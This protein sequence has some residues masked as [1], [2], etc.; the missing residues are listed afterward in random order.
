MNLKKYYKVWLISA[1]LSLSRA[2][3]TKTASLA[4]TLGKFI[5]FFFFIFFLFILGGNLGHISGYE[6]HQL[7][8]FYLVFNL[9]DIVG[10]VFFR[11]IYMFRDQVISGE[12]DFRLVKPLSPLFQALTRE[13]DLLDVPLLVIVLIA[14][15]RQITT[16]GTVNIPNLIIASVSSLV[17]ITAIH[18][19][20]A[21]FGLLTTQVDHTMWVYRDISSMVRFPVDIYNQTIRS[22]LTF[23]IPVGVIFTTPAKALMNLVNLSTL[24]TGFLV[25]I[26]FFVLAKVF[27][28]YALTKYSS[29]SS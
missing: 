28:N 25:S 27:W 7:L 6:Y 24:F 13:T 12:F 19:F 5:R 29:A 18:I 21:A 10:Q 23:V 4:F 15:G 16:L 9:F 20:I 26:T 11:G 1:K 17:L 2:L 8:T 14:L 22:L 3:A